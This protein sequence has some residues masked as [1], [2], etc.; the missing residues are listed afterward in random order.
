M[1]A[2][3][4]VEDQSAM[5]SSS[6]DQMIEEFRHYLLEDDDNCLPEEHFVTQS[7]GRT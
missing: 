3:V 6:G 2:A 4:D 1:A 5:S 7:V